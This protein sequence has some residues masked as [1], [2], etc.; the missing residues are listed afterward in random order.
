MSTPVS[1][2]SFARH[3]AQSPLADSI[4]PLVEMG[5]YEALWTRPEASFKS[6]A[7]L[8][9]SH[10]GSVPSDHVELTV[11][12]QHASGAN[13]LS[14]RAVVAREELVWVVG[15]EP[16]T[17]R[18]QAGSSDQAELHPGA[19][20]VVVAV[21][22]SYRDCIDA[23]RPWQGF[24]P[25]HV[26]GS[27]LWESASPPGPLLAR[28]DT[29]RALAPILPSPPA[30]EHLH[31]YYS[32]INDPRQFSKLFAG[33][34]FEP[35]I[36]SRAESSEYPDRGRRDWPV[37]IGKRRA[38]NLCV[39]AAGT[40]TRTTTDRIASDCGLRN[41]KLRHELARIQALNRET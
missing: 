10:E 31:F 20:V 16:T 34:Q 13:R 40:T 41:L 36:H 17:S 30:A 7:E 26:A 35:L 19:G 21:R 37:V 9:Q 18:I 11:A 27:T 1:L 28:A 29:C 33:H 23:C 8:F 25:S 12:E 5:A 2:A 24:R 4:S 6:L 38:P 32:S 14:S 3:P 39:A 15:F 22:S